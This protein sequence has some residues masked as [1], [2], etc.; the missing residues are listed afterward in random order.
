MQGCFLEICLFPLL[1]AEGQ[2]VKVFYDQLKKNAI[3]H[4]E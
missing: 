1:E 4:L 3:L 2:Q